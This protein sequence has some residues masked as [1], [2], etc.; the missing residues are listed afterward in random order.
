MNKRVI[1]FIQEISND[2]KVDGTG[3][4]AKDM[5][6]RFLFECSV[7]TYAISRLSGGE[8]RRLYYYVF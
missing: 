6:E 5:L 2:F 7:T 8:R 3:L 1:D 4:S